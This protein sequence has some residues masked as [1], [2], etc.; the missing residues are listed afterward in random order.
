MIVSNTHRVI[1]VHVPKTAGTSITTWI[2]PALR[3]ND[4]VI[5]GTDFGE[6][7]QEAYRQRFGLSKHMRARDIRRVVGP[8]L[9]DAYFSFVF[10]RHP[11]PRLLSF[12]LWQR[13]AIERAAPDA[14]LRSWPS[15]QA[16]LRARNFSEL[17][18]D[19]QFM[20]SLAARPQADWV[21]DD[22]G[23]CLVDFVGR[24]EDLEGGIRTVA[25]R[26]GLAV[27]N[28]R[29]L[30]AAAVGQPLGGH[31]SCAADYEHVHEMHRRDFEMFGYDPTLRL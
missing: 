8:H 4:L 25:D 17:I 5:G 30:N 12:Y 11:Y 18:R 22:E 31:F 3:W 21:C 16:H 23:G 27:G 9:W 7:V 2:E 20:G 28:L 1:F 14:P 10:V 19:E 24:F 6:S 29:A 13:A 15:I 26:M